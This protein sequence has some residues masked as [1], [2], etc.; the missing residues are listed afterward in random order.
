[1]EDHPWEEWAEALN[2]LDPAIFDFVGGEPLVFPRFVD[3][4]NRLDRKHRLAVTSNLYSSNFFKFITEAP[5]GMCLHFTGSWHPTGEEIGGLSLKGFAQRLRL[6]QASG[7]QVSVNIIDHES[8]KEHLG[9]AETL[10]ALGYRVHVSPYEH[11]PDLL[12]ANNETLT[13]NAGLNHYVLNNNGDVYRCLSWFRLVTMNPKGK[14]GYMGNIFDGS[15]KKLEERAPCNLK[16]EM[17]Y[18]VDQTNTMIKDLDIQ[19]VE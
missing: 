16:C 7:F 18:V 15:F 8:I 13:C 3:M 6:L 14:E 5:T 4:L 1:V 11:P 17:K 12:E 10:A 19:V 9:D 2:R